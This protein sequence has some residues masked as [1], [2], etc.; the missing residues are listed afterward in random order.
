VSDHASKA[1]VL[2][3]VVVEA[4]LNVL[5]MVIMIGIVLCRHLFVKVRS[6]ARLCIADAHVAD[7]QLESTMSY[8]LK[9][10][11]EYED[12][13]SEDAFDDVLGRSRAASAFYGVIWK[14][15]VEGN[16]K[17]SRV[18]AF[19]KMKTLIT[20]ENVAKWYIGVTFCPVHRFFHEPGPHKLIYDTL[21]VLYLGVNM[22][23]WR[24][25][26]QLNNQLA[27]IKAEGRHDVVKSE[28]E[29]LLNVL[30]EDKVYGSEMKAD[31]LGRYL[32]VAKRLCM[33]CCCGAPV[34]R[35]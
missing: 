20:G 7:H 31:T 30:T 19:K 18:N 21:H 8:K 22:S 13:D 6:S 35:D 1:F 34:A 10:V 3:V 26:L 23:A 25:A 5:F 9:G 27:L 14:S 2:V 29:R 24:R 4:C 11:C 28:G 12:D 32:G 15:F 16:T 33:S 17:D